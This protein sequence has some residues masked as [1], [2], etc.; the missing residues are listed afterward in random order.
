[1]VY[2]NKCVQGTGE[3][4]VRMTGYFHF[5]TLCSFSFLAYTT[6]HTA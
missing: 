2:W 4:K 3:E 6:G 1:M 5:S